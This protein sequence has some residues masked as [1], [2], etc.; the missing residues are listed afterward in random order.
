MTAT[1]GSLVGHRTARLSQRVCSIASACGRCAVRS[2]LLG[3]WWDIIG[4][5]PELP[6]ASPPR[7]LL[8]GTGRAAL[9]GGTRGF[10]VR[11]VSG[12]LTL[13]WGSR[14]I[15]LLKIAVWIVVAAGVARADLQP[16]LG[17]AAVHDVVEHRPK[18]DRVDER[19]QVPGLFHLTVAGHADAG[20]ELPQW[21][22]RLHR[23]RDGILVLC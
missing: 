16:R 3:T 12:M 14:M 11:N 18:L 8:A 20:S 10:E 9:Y 22:F 23:Q 19:Y 7:Y 6:L 15:N 21:R 4:R 17:G 5:L 2:Q 1:S 13:A